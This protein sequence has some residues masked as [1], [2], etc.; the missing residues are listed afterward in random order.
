MKDPMVKRAD[1]ANCVEKWF[2][3][4]IWEKPVGIVAHTHHSLH[5]NVADF[6]YNTNPQNDVSDIVA[7][8]FNAAL[9][10]DGVIVT[11]HKTRQTFHNLAFGSAD[12]STYYYKATMQMI[13]DTSIDP[14]LYPSLLI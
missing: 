8:D 10:K 13:M 12:P 1:F 11:I 7:E 4:S 3:Q 5:L 9:V 2:S 14:E 6:Y